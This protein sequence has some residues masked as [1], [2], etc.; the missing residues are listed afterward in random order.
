M[1]QYLEFH[2]RLARPEGRAA[3]PG[4]FDLQLALH[5][6]AD[7]EHVLWS[8]LHRDVLVNASG[9]V[10]LVLGRIV[11]LTAELF[12]DPPV[13]V[14]IRALRNGRPAEEAGPRVP[15][16]GANV[17]L[18][19]LVDEVASRVDTIEAANASSPAGRQTRSR[20]LKLH[21]RLRRLEA[22]EGV[23]GSLRHSLTTL[24]ARLTPIDKEGGRLD[25]LEDEIEEIVGPDGD[26]IDLLERVEKLEGS[27]PVPRP[28]A[29][30]SPSTTRLDPRSFAQLVERLI[31]T[32]KRLEAAEQ[33]L[34][35]VPVVTVDSLHAVKRGGDTMTGGLV[36]NRGGLDVLSGG[37]KSLGADV[38]TLDAT[39]HVKTPKLMTEALEL[40]G[41]LTVDNTKRVIQVRH[42]EG[43]A[44]SGR[45][46]GPLELN[47][48]SGEAVVVGNAEAHAGLAVHGITTADGFATRA[49]GVAYTFDSHGEIAPGDLVIV[50][51]RGKARRSEAPDD[52]QVIGVAVAQA[53]MVVGAT[54]A[55]RVLVATVGIV[56]CKANTSRGAIRPGAL[57]ATSETAGEAA[58]APHPTPGTLLG[59]AVTPLA[60]GSGEVTILLMPG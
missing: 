9:D 58:L 43:R 30:P 39:I 1:A 35:D 42:I 29:P 24:Q 16:T 10:D 4:T 22:G 25:A 41:D 6:D 46:D 53:M 52:A 28:A 49:G 51:E 21:R 50:D 56:R 19:G 8:E 59:K 32:E 31:A 17:T 3:S 33:K 45:K 26:I 7:T 57:L 55:G 54:G 36:I 14:S 18:A 13:W 38:H 11:P 15:M 44:G 34:E 5:A 23:V 37:I 60:T 47:A 20:V 12:L 27:G 40:R 2:G 48:R